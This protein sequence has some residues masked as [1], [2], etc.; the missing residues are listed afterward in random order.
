MLQIDDTILQIHV[1][2]NSINIERIMY[3]KCDLY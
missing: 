1:N 3:T 2:S